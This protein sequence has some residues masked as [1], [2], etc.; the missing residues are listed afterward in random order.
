MDCIGS[1]PNLGV[2]LYIVWYSSGHVHKRRWCDR[3]VFRV[4]EESE[5]RQLRPIDIQIRTRL[6]LLPSW[7]VARYITRPSHRSTGDTQKQE[8][9][10]AASAVFVKPS[11]AR[12]KLQCWHLCRP[13]P[14]SR[15]P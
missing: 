8:T 7:F 15:K 3:V 6:Q 9:A 1:G 5:P 12:S 13:G 4:A 14:E 2:M 11:R 10:V